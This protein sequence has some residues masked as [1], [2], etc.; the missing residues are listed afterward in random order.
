MTRDI[1]VN[2]FCVFSKSINLNNGMH[3]F[4]FQFRFSR[5]FIDIREKE[6]K[7]GMSDLVIITSKNPVLK[8]K[9]KRYGLSSNESIVDPN[10]HQKKF[11]NDTEKTFE[12]IELNQ[13]QEKKSKKLLSSKSKD[14]PDSELQ[15]IIYWLLIFEVV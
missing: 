6:K 10:D 3:I 8:K 13:W 11:K 2:D 14:I 4:S 7:R 9:Y 12:T 15:V 5:M 1:G